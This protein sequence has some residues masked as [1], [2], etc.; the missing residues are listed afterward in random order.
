MTKRFVLIGNRTSDLSFALSYY[1]EPGD[2][3]PDYNMSDV[4]ESSAGS[5]LSK[6]NCLVSEE[7][8]MDTSTVSDLFYSVRSKAKIDRQCVE[9]ISDPR[10]NANYECFDGHCLFDIQND[11]CE[12]RNVRKGN[13]E[14]LDEMINILERFKKNMTKQNRHDCDPDA[15]PVRFDGYWDNWMEFNGSASSYASIHY[16]DMVVF[17]IIFLCSILT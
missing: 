6:I 2:I 9:R 1:G 5:F 12:Y 7:D 14:I 16:N 8:C 13:Q 15:D 10:P 17:L 3:G 4:V 11:P